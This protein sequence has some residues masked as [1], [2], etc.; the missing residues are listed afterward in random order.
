ML[1]LESSVGGCA[2]KFLHVSVHEQR[3]FGPSGPICREAPALTPQQ[4]LFSAR[5][6]LNLFGDKRPARQFLRC[7]FWN[8]AAR[9][10]AGK[11]AGRHG[12]IIRSLPLQ[13][14]GSTQVAVDVRH[15]TATKEVLQ[16]TALTGT[17][18]TELRSL[19]LALLGSLAVYLNSGDVAG[20]LVELQPPPVVVESTVLGVCNDWND[21][22]SHQNAGE[23]LHLSSGTGS[24]LELPALPRQ[25]NLDGAELRCHVAGAGFGVSELGGGGGMINYGQILDRRREN[26]DQIREMFTQDA[27][28]GMMRLDQYSRYIRSI[29][30]QE[31]K[32][33]EC[34]RNRRCACFFPQKRLKS[35]HFCF[36]RS[37]HGVCFFSDKELLVAVGC[38][39]RFGKRFQMY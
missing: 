31:L 13:P 29:E 25:G 8:T 20:A 12:G 22:I 24:I 26:Q 5:G 1:H 19:V 21:R 10:E 3:C 18:L 35:L 28:M 23:E 39:N 15:G 33:K 9:F 17:V 34:T 16:P 14:S 6:T 38:S 11:F 2:A 7:S 27:W 4:Q 37:Q 36:S 30:E 32:C